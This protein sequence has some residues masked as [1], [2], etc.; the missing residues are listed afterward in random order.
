MRGNATDSDADEA[1]GTEAPE[2]SP[3]LTDRELVRPLAPYVRWQT[4]DPER[5]ADNLAELVGLIRDHGAQ[6]IHTAARAGC[7]GGDGKLWP[8]EI[9]DH[10]PKATVDSAPGPVRSP[11]H[12]R[13]LPDAI[14]I[15]ERLGY[16]EVVKRLGFAPGAITSDRQ[17]T[18][19]LGANVGACEELIAGEPS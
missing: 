10:L 1:G 2:G 4:N 12:D 3:L 8:N 18:M 5:S 6:V 7:I 13:I 14:A 9:L 16:A 15:A 17:L 19:V 11:E